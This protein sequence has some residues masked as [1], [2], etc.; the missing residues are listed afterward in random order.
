MAR[1]ATRTTRE[2][3]RQDSSMRTEDTIIKKLGGYAEK[4]K[5]ANDPMGYFATKVA[6]KDAAREA[7]ANTRRRNDVERDG[8]T[9]KYR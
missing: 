4:Y 1:Q 2:Y 9:V 7:N 8:K 6:Q 5:Q 3:D